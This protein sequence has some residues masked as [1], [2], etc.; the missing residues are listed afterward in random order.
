MKKN[1]IFILVLFLTACATPYQP[2]SM[3]SGGGYSDTKLQEDVFRINFHGNDATAYDRAQD[4][5]M[6]RAADVTL[7]NG[8]K[9][10][11]VL[12][13]SSRIKTDHY[14]TPVQVNTYQYPTINPA[15]SAPTHTSVSGGQTFSS[16]M[17]VASITIKCFRERPKDTS[18]FVFD[19]FEL[20]R[21]LRQ[22]YFPKKPV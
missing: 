19:A 15:F 12:E 8:F 22:N 9:Y 6:L 20:Q 11:L 16:N 13:D 10:F 4:F 21:N 18:I 2:Y 1:I 17:P 14:T 5:A 3:F 7:L